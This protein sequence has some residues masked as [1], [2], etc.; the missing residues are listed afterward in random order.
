MLIYYV[1]DILLLGPSEQ[2]VATIL[3]LLVRH[4]CAREW[5][6]N[7]TEVQ[8]P[9]TSVK[10]LGV[11]WCEACQ[12]ILPKVKEKLLYLAFPTTKEAQCRVDLFRF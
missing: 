1:D 2:K 3:G 5:E 7:L 12:D 10:L 6:I 8:G 11:R 9:S 4:L